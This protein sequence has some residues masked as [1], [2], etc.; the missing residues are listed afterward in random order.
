[1]KVSASLAVVCIL[2]GTAF[3][4]LNFERNYE[5]ANQVVTDS[6]SKSSSPSKEPLVRA[7]LDGAY[8]KHVECR[9]VSRMTLPV[10]ETNFYSFAAY[11]SLVAKKCK[12]H[13]NYQKYTKKAF[14]DFDEKAEWKAND[15]VK[16]VFALESIED[17]SFG[18]KLAG[19]VEK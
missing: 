13:Q 9:D 16:Y 5:T 4:H 8:G 18:L 14:S 17:K 2:A 19:V 10:N 15:L 7:F 12:P 1:M 3:S 11:Y 6:Y